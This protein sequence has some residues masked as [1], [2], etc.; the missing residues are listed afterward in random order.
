METIKTEEK[1]FSDN[2]F[3]IGY[4]NR[5]YEGDRDLGF[6]FPEGRLV[7]SKEFVSLNSTIEDVRGKTG[8]PVI[9]NI[10]DS[11]TSG[12]NGNKVFKGNKDPNAPFF[13]YKT[14]SDL[15]RKDP[16]YQNTIN[17]GVPGYTSLQG[18]KYLKRLLK[19]FAMKGVQVDYVTIYFG[20]NDATYNQYEDKVRLDVKK[21]SSNTRGERVSIRDYQKNLES[22]IDT[23][24]EYGVKPILISPPIHYDWEPGIRSVE[25]REE[26]LK[27]LKELKNTNLRKEVE[28]ARRLYMQGKYKE[29]CEKDRVLPRIK[30][31]YKRALK[32]VARKTRI[33]IIEVQRIIPLTDNDKYF[34]DYCHPLEKINQVIADS[35]KQIRNKDIF[36]VPIKRRIGNLISNFKVKERYNR[37]TIPSDIYTVY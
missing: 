29:A 21:E 37:D 35:V 4:D 32:K 25:H 33:P 34:I 8:Y 13:T 14:Y 30:G 26:S 5:M 20:N 7:S 18:R 9:L 23:A 12:W 31:Q 1:G 15:M 27:T 17:A 6:R 10:G 36:H 24:Q 2:P 22:M 11:S 19:R 3:M 28:T 16:T